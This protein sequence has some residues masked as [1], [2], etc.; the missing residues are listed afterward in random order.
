MLPAFVIYFFS[1]Q[2][3]V[4]HPGY[5][6]HHLPEIT[7]A[8]SR[9]WETLNHMDRSFA[10][11][12]SIFL[13]GHWWSLVVLVSGSVWLIWKDWKMG[14]SLVIGMI[15]ILFTLGI[16][17]VEE[18]VGVIF[19]SPTRMFLA[20]PLLLALMIGWTVKRIKTQMISA[21]LILL[22]MAF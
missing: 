14:V 11:L 1:K 7:Y 21:V 15:F 4:L 12:T 17:K 5:V 19:F 6:V 20:V 18:G 13:S 10:F 8:F 9:V 2:F 3:Y 16:N 22:S